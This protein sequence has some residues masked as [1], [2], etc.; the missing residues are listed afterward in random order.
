MELLR[1]LVVLSAAMALTG[2][3]PALRRRRWYA[4]WPAPIM[5]FAIAVGFG[6]VIALMGGTSVGLST[7]SLVLGVWATVVVVV[8]G[9]MEISVSSRQDL[10]ERAFVA[11]ALLLA[12]GVTVGAPLLAAQERGSLQLASVLAGL[13]IIA[14]GALLAAGRLW[15][16][17]QRIMRYA[18]PVALGLGAVSGRGPARR[19][20]DPFAE[21]NAEIASLE[22]TWQQRGFRVARTD[23]AALGWGIASMMRYR[24]ETSDVYVYVIAHDTISVPDVHVEPR[25]VVPPPSHGMPHLHRGPHILVVC[26]TND[27]RF[28]QQLDELVRALAGTDAPRGRPVAA[29]L[30][31]QERLQS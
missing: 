23:S 30:A 5:A 21:A 18:W 8:A 11:P 15:P 24:V 7:P 17:H 29:G 4:F 28:A 13:F 6:D 25:L 10:P 31:Q 2:V 26:V 1:L 27:W 16:I 3:V 9:V 14:A 19:P 22:A 12:A 20:P